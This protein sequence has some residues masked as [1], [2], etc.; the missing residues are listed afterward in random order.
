M[1]KVVLYARE[2]PSLAEN[3]LTVDSQIQAL[4]ERIESDGNILIDLYVD[5][6]YAGDL[7]ARPDLDRFRDDVS[8]RKFEVAYFFDRGRLA[9]KYSL[10][11]LVLDELSDVGIEIVFLHEKRAE[12]AEEKILEGVRGIFAEYE[13]EKIKERTRRGRLHRAKT[14]LLVGHEAPFGYRYVR[15]DRNKEYRYFEIVEEDA[16]VVRMIFSWVGDEGCSLM[17][18]RRRLHEKG[19]KAQKSGKTNWQNSTLSR[20]LRR[21][22]YVGTA[23]YN[24]TLPVIPTN[25][26]NT[27]YK[28]MKK[29]GRKYKDQQEWLPISVPAIIDQELFDRVQQQLKRNAFFSKRNQKHPYLLSGLLFCGCG[30]DARMSGDGQGKY[31]YY[32]STD[33]IRSFPEKRT[34]TQLSISVDRAEKAVWNEICRFLNNPE[35]I[36]KQLQKINDNKKYEL[37]KFESELRAIETKL[38]KLASEEQLIATAYRK[39]ALSFEQLGIQMA[40]INKTRASITQDKKA[41][42]NQPIKSDIQV[43]PE[44]VKAYSSLMK[45]EL[46]NYTFEEKQELLR[47]LVNKIIATGKRLTIQGELPVATIELDNVSK[48]SLISSSGVRRNSDRGGGRHFRQFPSILHH[49][50]AS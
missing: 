19:K 38:E 13:R 23:Y 15:P 30:C 31:R 16:E 28:R 35:E 46:P 17:E 5:N 44:R 6:G 50:R 22:D 1:K 3:E 40:D 32:R 21:T 34:C 8:L 37:E 49:S 12:N 24:K 20:L 39:E 33:R 9:R 29:T 18:V 41:L 26:R 42:L 47:L 43:S 11:E 7:L 27:G 48:G 10:Q 14:G 25:P 36:L 2:S 45:K 4:K